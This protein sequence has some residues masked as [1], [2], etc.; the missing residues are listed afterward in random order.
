[1]NKIITLILALFSGVSMTHAQDLSTMFGDTA[2]SKKNERT[3]ATFKGTHMINFNT[4]EVDGKHTLN[5]R[6]QHR[7]GDF[8]TGLYNFYGVDG[9]ASIKLA[10]DYSW[11]G[12]T[13]VGIGRCNID[14]MV[15]GYIKYR[16]LRQTTDNRMPISVTGM[17]DL[18]INTTNAPLSTPELYQNYSSRLNYTYQIM[19]ARKFTRNFSLQVSP[20]LVHIN[21]VLNLTDKNDIYAIES[22]L[23]YKFTKRMAFTLEYAARLNHYSDSYST[24]HNAF[25]AGV[26]I[27]TGG[28][29]FS[30]H[31]T[32]CYG[33]NDAQ[34]LPYTTGN[35]TKGNLALGFNISRVFSW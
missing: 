29:V 35:I 10:L 3:I 32:N 31:V 1:M 19:I 28:H 22:M 13:E 9:P 4:I 30:I 20:T 15:D 11:D 23:R 33:I 17:V 12:R 7:F 34:F 18:G 8:S 2:K 5:F 27:E 24:Y 21:E 6:I 16:A 26:D 14:K 25:G